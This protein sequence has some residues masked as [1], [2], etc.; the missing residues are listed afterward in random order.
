MPGADKADP[1]EQK[2]RFKALRRPLRRD[3]KLYDYE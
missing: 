1:K 3:P 2:H